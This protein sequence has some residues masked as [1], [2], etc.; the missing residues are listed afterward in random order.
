MFSVRC[1]GALASCRTMA[2]KPTAPFALAD[3]VTLRKNIELGSVSDL[4]LSADASIAAVASA[5]WKHRELSLL[6]LATGER[7]AMIPAAGVQPMYELPVWCT[8]GARWAVSAAQWS[9]Q[10][11]R[12]LVT[13]GELGASA[14]L[15]TIETPAYSWCTRN[16]Q[17][18]PSPLLSWEPDGSGL[19]QRSIRRD[20][21]NAIISIDLKKRSADALWLHEDECDVMAQAVGDDRSRYA[22][23]A[24]PGTRGGLARYA[25]GAAQPSERWE[26]VFG[27]QLV[28]TASGL[29]ALG[30]SGYGF[31]LGPGA[32]R[33]VQRARKEREARRRTLA[34]RAKTK[35]DVEYITDGIPQHID[36]TS[37]VIV[38]RTRST[39]ASVDGDPTPT[40]GVRCFETEL[41][42]ESTDASSL[43]R[44]TDELVVS[45]GVA[46]W[47]WSLTKK[48]VERALLIDD[49]QRCTHR[50]ARITAISAANRTLAVVWKKD[51]LGERCVLSIF[52]VR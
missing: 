29:W 28:A 22:L 40:E 47:K 20:E 48:G 14:P 18:R 44:S 27:G 35:W 17:R 37:S 13:V 15:C 51:A 50:N 42:W 11:Q 25:A 46:V 12:G 39:Y 41:L 36:P 16:N 9:D 43:D 24:S 49:L 19:V 21:R 6:E 30:Y 5:T 31:F 4:S 45:D 7:T 10:E 33:P 2:G 1:A 38:R 52:T 34:A 32:A 8:D 23:C 26:W 3:G